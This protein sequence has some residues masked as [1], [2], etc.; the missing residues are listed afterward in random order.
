MASAQR[1][2]KLIARLAAKCAMLGKAQVMGIYGR[3]AAG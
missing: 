2:G 1:H 3:A